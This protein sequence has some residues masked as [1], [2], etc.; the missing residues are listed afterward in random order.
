MVTDTKYVCCYSG[1]HSSALVA[2]EAARK[3]GAENVI[4][5]N[6]DISP[7][8][9]HEDIKR[10]K[11]EVAEYLG[12][13]ITTANHPKYEN[14]TPLAISREKNAFQFRPGQA[15][16]THF[17]KTRPF[18]MWLLDNYPASSCAPNKDIVILYGFDANE[19]ERI[20]R[21]RKN[22][23]GRGYGT[24][25]PLALWERTITDIEEIGIKRPITYSIFKHA[26]C[27]GC[28]KAGRQHWYVVFCLYPDIFDEAVLSEKE[29]GYSIIK[30]VFLKELICKFTEMK[31]R[32]IV[33]NDKEHAQT[34]WAKVKRELGDEPALPCE[35]SEGGAI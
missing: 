10:F 9:E 2:V 18:E 24:D 22:L 27:T 19:P 13:E 28:L 32:G 17:L 8:V 5:L 29:I 23:E 15:L 33:P 11:R 16:C 7:L 6:H 26:N 30:G 12:V 34:F 4:L 1:G 21:R 25:F 14:M 3:H 35:C 31:R 20:E